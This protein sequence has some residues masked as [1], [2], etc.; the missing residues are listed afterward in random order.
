[1]LSAQQ[2]IHPNTCF[3][4]KIFETESI[5]LMSDE[6][7]ALLRRQFIDG[8]SKF[9]CQHFTQVTSFRTGGFGCKPFV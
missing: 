8:R 9:L 1:M 2:R 3:S 7:R 6:H 5:Q 4:G